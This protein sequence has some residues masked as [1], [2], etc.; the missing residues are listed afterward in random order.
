MG[1][2]IHIHAAARSFLHHQ[3]RSM[4]GCL[5]LVGRGQ[6]QADDIGKALYRIKQHDIKVVFGPGR[7]PP[8]DSVFFYFL[9]PDSN[10]V[11]T[12]NLAGTEAAADDVPF[13][14]TGSTDLTG[15]MGAVACKQCAGCVAADTGSI[16]VL[17]VAFVA[18]NAT[19]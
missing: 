4:V 13:A 9:D 15:A 11:P 6:W 12:P 1:E 8:S 19:F 10:A 2:E 5:A 18:N 14:A 3:V 17:S 16:C 7:H